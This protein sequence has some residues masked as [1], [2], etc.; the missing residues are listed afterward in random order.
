MLF[1][2]GRTAYTVQ[3]IY[4]AEPASA[5]APFGAD[6]ADRAQ[7]VF[8][9]SGGALVL[10]DTITDQL[11]SIYGDHTQERLQALTQGLYQAWRG[12]DGA[13]YYYKENGE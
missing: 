9:E 7:Q 12:T 10:F 8:V 5:Y 1:L 2:A 13:I 11:S 3:E 6:P 4:R